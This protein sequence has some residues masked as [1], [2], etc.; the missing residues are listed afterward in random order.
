M[1]PLLTCQRDGF[2]IAY[3]EPRAGLFADIAAQMREGE[4]VQV[5]RAAQR[6]WQYVIDGSRQRVRVREGHVEVA[7]AY[8]AHGTI[9][10]QERPDVLAEVHSPATIHAV[11]PIRA[12]EAA[13]A[14]ALGHIQLGTAMA[15]RCLGSPLATVGDHCTGTRAVA[16]EAAT[17]I[18][19]PRA[20]DASL[21]IL[22]DPLLRLVRRGTVLTDTSPMLV[23]PPALLC[24]GLTRGHS[25]CLRLTGT[26]VR[27]A[28]VPK[29]Q[30]VRV[31][32]ELTVELPLATVDTASSLAHN[33]PPIY[34]ST[35]RRACIASNFFAFCNA[36]CSRSS[37]SPS[38]SGGSII[39]GAVFERPFSASSDF[40]QIW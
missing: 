11:S 1:R 2:A 4:V 19:R 37:I 8:R 21:V 34:L 12:D 9:P 13:A 28:R 14:I 40:I 31:A 32:Q 15:T 24:A 27:R 30:V 22:D 17:G 16:P 18:D 23:A 6:T 3:L 33:L 36:R 20:D 10:R 7:G 5:L 38:Y 25:A 35:P 26:Q 39:F 29:A